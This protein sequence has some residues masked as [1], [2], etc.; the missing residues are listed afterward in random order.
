VSRFIGPTLAALRSLSVYEEG[1]WTPTIDGS[2]TFG[3]QTYSAQDGNY[4][5]VGN[6]VTVWGRV[7]LSGTSGAV[8]FVIIGGLPFATGTTVGYNQPG[9]LGAIDNL[10]HVTSGAQQFGIRSRSNNTS[11]IMTEF[12]EAAGAANQS[13]SVSALSSTTSINFSCTYRIN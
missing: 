10:A 11:L 7:T 4:V 3:T 13:L 6:L 9:T 2:T 5:R 12:G 1:T 8:G